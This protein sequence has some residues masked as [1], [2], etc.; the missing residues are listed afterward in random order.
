MVS[1]LS[2]NPGVSLFMCISLVIVT[3]SPLFKVF[4]IFVK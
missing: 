3:V 2:L 1:E 4:S